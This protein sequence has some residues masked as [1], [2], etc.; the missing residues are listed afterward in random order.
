MTLRD[1]IEAL[2]KECDREKNTPGERWIPG[3][4]VAAQ[5][6][7]LLAEADESPLCGMCNGRGEIMRPMGFEGPVMG[8]CPR[9]EGSGVCYPSPIPLT[10]PD[11][12]WCKRDGRKLSD[13]EL[14]WVCGCGYR[15]G[16]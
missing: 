1:R 7:A 11:C 13:M 15:E 9:C 2:A 6:R 5:L 12:P 8:E 4:E 3:S 10:A 14:Q 16:V